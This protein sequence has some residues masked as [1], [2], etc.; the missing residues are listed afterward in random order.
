MLYFF[1]GLQGIEP[2]CFRTGLQPGDSPFV[3]R[4]KILYMVVKERAVRAGRFPLVI[5]VNVFVYL[6]Q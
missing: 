3:I 6:C 1:V 2:C 5:E 4:P